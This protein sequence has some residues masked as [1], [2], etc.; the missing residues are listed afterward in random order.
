MRAEGFGSFWGPRQAPDGIEVPVPF[1]DDGE[2][3]LFLTKPIGVAGS[4]ASVTMETDSISYADFELLGLDIAAQITMSVATDI[5]PVVIV[6]AW[7]ISGGLSQLYRPMTVTQLG[8]QVG[9]SGA[10]LLMISKSFP[11]I[12]QDKIPLG[13]TNTASITMDFNSPKDNTGRIDVIITAN[14]KLRITKDDNIPR[15]K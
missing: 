15:Y 4:V 7:G 1:E 2:P 9:Q 8:G 3:F 12:R 10:G 13:R 6:T 5:P 11:A 14:L